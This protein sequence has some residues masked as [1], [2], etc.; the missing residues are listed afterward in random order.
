MQLS[1]TKLYTIK[2]IKEKKMK[3]AVTYEHI[4]RIANKQEQEEE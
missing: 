4:T 2:M 1:E 3:P